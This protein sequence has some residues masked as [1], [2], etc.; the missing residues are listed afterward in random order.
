[1]AL[2]MKNTVF[3]V[4]TP[5]SLI[6]T[7]KRFRGTYCLHLQDRKVSHAAYYS[8]LNMEAGHLSETLV[9]YLPDYMTSHPRR[10]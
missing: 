5:H 3:W 1:M 6:D 2:T 7:Y 8:T 9:K 10:Q 4:V